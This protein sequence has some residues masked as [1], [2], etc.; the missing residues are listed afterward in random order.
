MKENIA[1]IPLMDAFQAKDECP[2]CY[3]EREAEQH[4]VSFILGSRIYGG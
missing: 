1:T 3:L 2:F 4:A